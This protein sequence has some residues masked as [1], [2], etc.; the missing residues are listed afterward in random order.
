M[1]KSLRRG[2]RSRAPAEPVFLSVLRKQDQY[3][4]HSLQ[5]NQASPTKL[6]G[7]TVGKKTIRK[8]TRLAVWGG[9]GTHQKSPAFMCSP[10]KIKEIKTIINS[11]V[12]ARK[13]GEAAWKC[14]TLHHV[15][16]GRLSR[17]IFKGLQTER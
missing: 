14:L 15:A 9:G 1:E 11:P 10:L 2:T 3:V 8:N 6:E 4:L 13:V 12:M 5:A 17:E 7:M 16:A